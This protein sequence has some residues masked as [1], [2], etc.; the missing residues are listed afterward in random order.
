M[1]DPYVPTTLTQDLSIRHKRG[2]AAA[3]TAHNI[4]LAAGEFGIET[5]TRRL[6]VGDGTTQWINL[7][8][9][10]GGVRADTAANFTGNNPLLSKDELAF[11]TDRNRFKLGN[12][13]A[14]WGS[15]P[16]LSIVRSDVVD[17]AGAAVI[18]NMVALTSAQY[19][20]LATK[21]A[22]TLYIIVD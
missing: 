7:P 3:M 16:Y 1:P 15:L 20:A 11:E 19:I 12:G 6:K 8:Y 10:P 17:I 9:V 18:T 13:T 22:A 4:T 21:D 14:R 5:D 2:T